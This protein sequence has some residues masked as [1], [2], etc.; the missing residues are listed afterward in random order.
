MRVTIV[1]L[2]KSGMALVPWLKRRGARVSVSDSRPAYEFAGWLESERGSIERAEF[3]GNSADLLSQSDLVV[4]SPGVS[5]SSP[6]LA[7]AARKGI[8][9]VGDIEVALAGCPAR[10]AAVTGTNGKTTTT[11]LLGHLLKTAGRKVEIAGNIGTPVASVVDGLTPDHF[12]VLEV[13]SFQLDTAPS[14]HPAVALL[15]NITPD[16]LDRYPAMP[17]YV[18]SKARIFSNQ[19]PADLAILNRNDAKCAAMAP[20]IRARVRWFDSHGSLADG[21][22]TRD[23]WVVLCG[24]GAAERILPAADISIRGGHNL[25]NALA[26]AMA[27]SSLG[28]PVAAIAEGLRTFPGVPHRL[29]PVG[30]IGDVEFVNDSKGTNTDATEKALLSFSEPVVLIAGGRDKGQDFAPMA[31]LVKERV[32]AA[33][34]IGEATEKMEKAWSG[35]VPTRRASSMGEAVRLGLELAS[36]RGVVL[37]S[38]ACASFDMFKNYEHRGDMFREAVG[39]LSGGRK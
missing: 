20:N 28:V 36:P 18:A 13:S 6:A 8:P 3:G 31:G 25:E 21:A 33:I 39:A 27:A 9:V 35:L 22:G 19:G 17:D 29:E 14:F 34:L 38:P 23:G 11:A 30:R 5:P 7:E 12:L 15:L 1:G 24:G 4:V 2:G 16:H 26:A 37:L 10:I 32:K